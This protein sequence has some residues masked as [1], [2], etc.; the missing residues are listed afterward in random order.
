[1][2]WPR[3]YNAIHQQ[4]SSAA[5]ESVLDVGEVSGHLPHPRATGLAVIPPISTLRDWRSIT[6]NTQCRTKAAECHDLHGEEV[7]GGDRAQVW[8]QEAL[9]AVGPATLRRGLEPMLE[10]D[11]PDR[12]PADVDS[13]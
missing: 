2:P 3:G 12:A 11:P 10:Q 9:P 7:R 6:T 1:M 8:A 13:Q 5:K 4:E